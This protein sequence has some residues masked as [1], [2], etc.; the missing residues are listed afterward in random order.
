M[1][2]ELLGTNPDGSPHYHYIA[3]DGETV[4]L[5]GPIVAVLTMED[6]TQYDVSD[7]AV[8]V[9][10]EHHDELVMA[11]G[12]HY[13]ANGHPHHSAPDDPPF[14]HDRTHTRK[15]LKARKKALAG[16]TDGED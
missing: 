12:D 10:E 11:I 8:A 6:G 13:E 7:A 2:K 15:T 1:R 16:E 14:V 4:I 9:P 5:T 3:E